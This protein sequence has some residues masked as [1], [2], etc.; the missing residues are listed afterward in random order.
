MHEGP[1]SGFERKHH[2]PTRRDAAPGSPLLLPLRWTLL[3]GIIHLVLSTS[4]ERHREEE[5]VLQ[6]P[7]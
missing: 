4:V 2:L 5:K 6:D 3:A 1:E 7:R